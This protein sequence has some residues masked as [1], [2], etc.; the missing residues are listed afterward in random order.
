MALIELV[1]VDFRAAFPAF[2][3]ETLYPDA[4]LEGKYITATCIYSNEDE[5]VCLSTK[6]RTRV[7]YLTLAHLL[8]IDGLISQGQNTVFV[9]GATVDRVS[10]TATPPKVDDQFNLWLSTTPYGNEIIA[11]TTV[12]TAGGFYIGGA[13]ERAAFRRVGGIFN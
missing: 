10:V 13:P 8:H 1:V 11:I 12:A 4:L 7:L 2:A 3:N 9:Q 6:Q 5:G